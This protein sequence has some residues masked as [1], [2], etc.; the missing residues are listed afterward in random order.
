MTTDQLRRKIADTE[1]ILGGLRE[2]LAKAE[3]KAAGTPPPPCGLDLLWQAALPMARQRSSK[4]RCRTAWARLP[5]AV[6]PPIAV[7][8]A[9]LKAWNRCD[10]WYKNDH[11]FAPGLHRFIADR[12]WEDLPESSKA[13]PLSRYRITPKP[14]PPKP[15]ANEELSPAEIARLLSL[16]ATPTETE[17]D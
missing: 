7:A 16:H 12:M 1:A 9:A 6:R 5:A 11:M 8:V 10:E 14:L 13:D 2:K 17:N 4:H 3:A 15:A